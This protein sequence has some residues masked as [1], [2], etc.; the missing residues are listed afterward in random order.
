MT[1]SQ[2]RLASQF[3]ISTKT[4]LAGRHLD[5]SP[6]IGG[7]FQRETSANDQR[8]K[9][10]KFAMTAATA[11]IDYEE[12]EVCPHHKGEEIIAMDREETT[13]SGQPLFGCDKCVFERKLVNPVFLAY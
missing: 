4:E 7:V 6:S 3:S 9:A 2:Q 1:T 13:E 10:A 5:V 8:S 11:L 12:S